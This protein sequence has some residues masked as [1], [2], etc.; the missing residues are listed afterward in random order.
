MSDEASYNPNDSAFLLSRSLDEE[1]TE[2]EQQRLDEALAQSASLRADAE[3]L[4]VLDRLVKRWGARRA[5]LDFEGHAAL[6]LAQATAGDDADA[7]ERVDQL[8]ARWGST[9]VAFDA[10]RFT[11][12]VMNRVALESGWEKQRVWIFR[13]GAPLA[14]AAAIV[15]AVI[16][17][18]WWGAQREAVC[19]IEF[20][21]RV[22]MVD[23]STDVAEPRSAVVSFDRTPIEPVVQ[24][25]DGISFGAVGSSALAE[26]Y[27]ESPPL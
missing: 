16:G 22:A 3:R 13:L 18:V 2:E 4:R 15:L 21:R 17:S 14:A 24:A 7:L 23:A 9:E 10:D 8:I 19:R 11:S 5:A 6:I 27:R 26:V 1:L 25:A 12:A 20:D